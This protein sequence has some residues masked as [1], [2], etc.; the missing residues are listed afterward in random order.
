MDVYLSA[1]ARDPPSFAAL[2]EADRNANE[3]NSE[4]V[5]TPGPGQTE[6]ITPEE[7][8]SFDQFLRA[9]GSSP[10]VK[11]AKRVSAALRE[12]WA[13]RDRLKRTD[14][15]FENQC[16][17]A[18]DQ[19]LSEARAAERDA[20]IDNIRDVLGSSSMAERIVAAIEKRSAK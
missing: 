18:G 13:E 2:V 15:D 10:Q 12:A 19:R 9:Y 8:D 17:Q 3:P 7:L 14:S 16:R 20:C 1:Q 6:P 4:R 5:R 11:E